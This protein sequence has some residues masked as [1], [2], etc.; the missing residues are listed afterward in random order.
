MGMYDILGRRGVQ[1]KVCN[2]GMSMPH[3]AVGDRVPLTDGIYVGYEGAVVIKNH[4][5][6]AEF[7]HLTDKWGG[8]ML[9][10]DVINRNNPLKQVV[11]EVI[12][13][14]TH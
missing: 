3:Y 13:E 11:E 6:I 7:G 8:I 1:L 9:C 10:K 2:D 5:F 12:D 14:N 4:I